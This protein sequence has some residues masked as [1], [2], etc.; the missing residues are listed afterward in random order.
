[1]GF[2]SSR[3]RFWEP[4][5]SRLIFLLIAIGAFGLTEFGRYVYRPYVY[6]N[7]IADFGLADSVG[8]LGGIIVQVFLSLAILNS[9]HAQSYRLAVFF[10]VGHVVYEFAQPYLPRGVFDWSDIYGTAI[11]YGISVLLL[12]VVWRSVGVAEKTQV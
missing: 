1:M 3:E 5:R 12:K 7:G 8:N 10:S 6:Q 4:S 9:T 11:G 2:F